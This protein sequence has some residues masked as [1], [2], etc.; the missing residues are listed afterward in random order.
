MGERYSTVICDKMIM[1]KNNITAPVSTYARHRMGIDGQGVTT[2]V[3]F[4]G[5]ILR[6]AWCINSFALN[7]D[8]G[9]QM[10][11]PSQLYEKLK[12]D[13]LY[14][15]ATNGGVTFGGGEPLLYAD[16]I[17]EFR[18]CCGKDWHI[19][20]ETSLAVSS[21]KV[22]LAA[23]CVDMFYVDVKDTNP[24][25]YSH[26]TGGDCGLMLNNLKELLRQVTPERVVVRLPHIPKF[27]T[28][29]DV[30]KSR[31]LLEKMGA[32]HFDEFNYIV[33]KE[34]IDK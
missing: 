9:R 22:K 24:E 3:C 10:M 5:C 15:L 13:E 1:D 2:L 31:K 23:E 19:C 27:N 33:G 12:I 34:P 29:E 30:D 6:C 18:N 16:F 21:D 20:A 11:T 4:H 28:D 14:F 17:K 7:P 32:K 25:I 8:S 26:Y